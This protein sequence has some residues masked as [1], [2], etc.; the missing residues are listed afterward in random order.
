[1]KISRSIILSFVFIL[2]LFAITT[3]ND[4]R[5]SEEI[6]EETEYLTKSTEIIKNSARFQRNVLSMESGLR[7][8]WLTGDNS[9]IQ[10]YNAASKDNFEILQECAALV[11]DSAQRDLL[12]EMATLNSQWTNLYAE[13]LKTVNRSSNIHDYN[14]R[15][16]E[17]AYREKFGSGEEE[18]IQTQLLDKLKGF[19]Q[20]EYGIREKR[21]EKLT[22]SVHR[23]KTI[24][25]LLTIFSIIISILVIYVLVRKISRRIGQMTSLANNIAAGN[26]STSI[27]DLGRDELSSLGVSL[28]NMADELAKNIS[29]LEHS[30]Q[31]LDQ[32][33]HIVSHDMKSPLRGISN[34]VSW[35]E[36]DYGEDLNPKVSDYLNLIKGRIIRAE[37][38]IEGLLAYARINKEPHEKEEVIVGDMI[39]EIAENIDEKSVKIEYTKMPVLFT[40]RL[41]LF[42]VFSN[43]IGN[44]IKHNPK[45]ENKIVSISYIE[46]D[47][48]YEF[49]VRDNG[50][51][52]APQH[53]QR[54]FAI[55]QTLKEKDAL[56]SAGVGLAI[57][58]KILESQK[59]SITIAS[60]IGK[61]TIFS[62]TWPKEK[63]E[64]N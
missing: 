29:L 43:L 60:E 9:F 2:L 33:A 1:M 57:V 49:H 35:I 54:I 17:K 64:V 53:Y 52:I 40:Y 4:Y 39:S 55:F 31:E 15:T 45:K 25:Y 51:G 26:Y 30:N 18:L 23:I 28:N 46:S 5:L 47:D 59:Q 14:N 22:Q 61:G 58:K 21:Q 20:V 6:K 16:F 34:V 36:E 50:E 32:F 44:A 19:A 42:Q 41:L 62:F 38:L 10:T 7:G 13:P 56:E 37:N 48:K 63:H 8:Y 24:S 3:Y 12:Q 27:I 11:T